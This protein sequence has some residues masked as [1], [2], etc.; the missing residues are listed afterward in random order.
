MNWSHRRTEALLPDHSEKRSEHRY[1]AEG[2]ILF[3]FDDPLRHEVTGLL[4]DHSN[5]GF[6]ATHGYPALASG[7][8]VAF[9]HLLASGE[10]K[11]VWNR[12]VEG[13]I[14]SGFIILR[15]QRSA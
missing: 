11:V 8:V 10:A 14:E 15:L 7:Q 2:E 9:Q 12:I 3:S 13:I 5:N 4:R 6:R 1:R